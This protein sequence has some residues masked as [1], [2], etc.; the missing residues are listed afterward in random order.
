MLHLSNTTRQM[1]KLKKHRSNRSLN[2][3]NRRDSQRKSN[4]NMSSRLWAILTDI[5]TKPVVVEKKD[6][7]VKERDFKMKST[8]RKRKMMSYVRMG[9]SLKRIE[10]KRENS[11]FITR[12][13]NIKVEF[14]EKYKAMCKECLIYIIKSFEEKQ[15]E[16]I[17][18]TNPV[19]FNLH[20]KYKKKEIY[21]SFKLN[22]LSLIKVL[23]KIFIKHK[24]IW[25]NPCD[26]L[27]DKIK[28]ELKVFCNKF[29]KQ[30]VTIVFS[31]YESIF[32]KLEEATQ[33]KKT[34]HKKKRETGLVF[35]IKQKGVETAFIRKILQLRCDQL[36]YISEKKKKTVYS[37]N[38]PKQ[39]IIKMR[40]DNINK[41]IID[42][43]LNAST[44]QTNGYFFKN[45]FLDVKKTGDYTHLINKKDEN[46]ISIENDSML[47]LL[48]PSDIKR[49]ML[50]KKFDQY[51]NSIILKEYRKKKNDYNNLRKNQLF[52]HHYKPEN[53]KQ[54]ERC[55]KF[56]KN[57]RIEK[58]S[59]SI[60]KHTLANSNGL[61][62]LQ[63]N[64]KPNKGDNRDTNECLKT[65][66]ENF[67]NYFKLG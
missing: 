29:S 41:S 21:L 24:H 51:K 39:S 50:K 64:N 52:R 47:N 49:S 62:I 1:P 61:K 65:N 31:K 48:D 28:D 37:I 25:K 38:K 12:K 54:I 4:T 44:N 59:F 60:L 46:N 27:Y 5:T 35:E 63:M 15:G 3:F 66:I 14:E 55:L 8:Q 36:M 57:N 6:K 18:N 33:I 53:G 26:Q 58:T 13:A 11:L 42:D 19:A 56:L 7:T 17:E 22:K 10:S 67:G 20:L 40:R 43:E 45:N 23:I 30:N 9:K 16:S 34:K 2:Q 32:C